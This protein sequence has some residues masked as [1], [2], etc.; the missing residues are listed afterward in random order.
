MLDE[1]LVNRLRRMFSHRDTTGFNVFDFLYVEGS[2]ILALWYSRLFWPNF[3]EYDGMIFLAETIE[4]EEDQQRVRDAH[5]RFGRD[6]SQTEKSFNFVE[7]PRLFGQQ[8]D[9]ATDEEYGLLADRLVEMWRCRL[10]LVFPERNFVVARI[11]PNSDIEGVGILFH[12][13]Q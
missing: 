5:E 13:Q 4:D 7:L 10:S 8:A 2:P 1:I 12:Q 3:V 6:P 9:Q 11:D